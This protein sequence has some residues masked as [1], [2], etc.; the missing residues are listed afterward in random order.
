MVAGYFTKISLTI[1]NSRLY[2]SEEPRKENFWTII[3]CPD[4]TVIV[5]PAERCQ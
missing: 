3:I 5:S 4:L 1:E 2:W